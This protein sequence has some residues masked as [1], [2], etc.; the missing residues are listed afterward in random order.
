MKDLVVFV[1]EGYNRYS[2]AALAG[3]LDQEMPDLP[4]AFL[5]NRPRL[6]REVRELAEGHRRVVL[7][8]SFMT[9][10]LPEILTALENL[11]P[12][13]DN[14]MLVAGGPHASGDPLGTLQLGFDVVVL[15]EGEHTFPELL[16]RIFAEELFDRFDGAQYTDVAGIAFL[17]AAE[18]NGTLRLVRTPRRPWTDLNGYPPFSLKHRKLA[19]I[20]ITRGCPWACSFCQTPFFLGGRMRYRTVEQIVYWLRRAKEEVG[21][22]YARFISADCFCYGSPDGRTPDL[23]SVE[24]LLYEVSHLMGKENTFFGSFPSEVRPNSVSREGIALIR[25]YCANDNVVIGAQSGSPRMLELIRRGHT[26]E[27]VFRASEI[28][29]AA[30][31]KCLVDFIFGLPGETPADRELTLAAIQRL[32]AMGATI[33]SHF[34]MPLPGTP[35]ANSQPGAPDAET[36]LFL[37]RLTSDRQELGR[38]K[39]RLANLAAVEE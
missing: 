13:P 30:G 5:Q 24:R 21:M 25:K 11:D 37:E 32:T 9:P 31:L 8:F 7:A 2:I 6:G 19:A 1:I 26:I 17:T 3:L 16:H 12:R 20:E 15:G 14:V 4:L 23:E 18:G 35:L 39:G 29:V 33:N 36:L 34:F 27:D 38:W 10:Q 22:R 28:I